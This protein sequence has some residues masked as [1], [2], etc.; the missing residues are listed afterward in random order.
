M[1][2]VGA[3]GF[4]C[5]VPAVNS[6]AA[7]H[8]ANNG[9]TAI[10]TTTVHPG[11]GARSI[12]V[13]CSGAAASS[14]GMFA[15]AFGV[16]AGA[17]RVISFYVYIETSLPAANAELFRLVKSTAGRDVSIGFEQSSSKICIY[18]Q[19]NFAGRVLGP[20]IAHSSWVRVDLYVNGTALTADWRVNGVAQ[21]QLAIG[22]TAGTYTE[23]LFG[24]PSAGDVAF[25]AY[26]AYYDDVVLSAT[27]GDYPLTDSYIVPYV[28]SAD[29]A[30]NTGG[31]SNFTN[32]AGTAITDATTTAW[33]NL[34]EIPPTTT[35]R[36]EQR[37]DTSG[38]RYVE[39]RF[40][41]T[42]AA[43][44]PLS[45]DFT[46]VWRAATAA[47]AAG[48]IKMRDG[49]GATDDAIVNTT[50]ALN[51]DVYFAKHYAA[52]PAALGAWTQA[53]LQDLRARVGFGT[54][55]TPD[56]WF[57]GIVAE[58]RFSAVDV[59]TASITATG[60]GIATPSSAKRAATS[61][62][63][64]GGGVLT[65]TTTTTR[66]RTQA[67][68]G[69]GVA[70]VVA[71]TVRAASVAV[72]GG[73]VATA[74]VQK[75]GSQT[76][77]ATGGG[78]ATAS[79]AKRGQVSLAATG[80]GVLA[81][82][83]STTRTRTDAATGGGVATVVAP[84]TRPATVGVSGGGSGVVGGT[85]IHPATVVTTGAGALSPSSSSIRA[86]S[87]GIT[88]GGVAT[89]DGE[90]V[91]SSVRDASVVVT[92]AGVTTIAA[93]TTRGASV[94]TTG[95]GV[96]VVDDV[97]I[98]AASI[99]ATG[100]GAAAVSGVKRAAAAIASSGSGIAIAN[101]TSVRTASHAATGAG[102]I[103]IDAETWRLAS[104]IATGGGA[105]VVFGGLYV[106]PV[107]GAVDVSDSPRD[108]LVSLDQAARHDIVASAQ[109]LELV[110]VGA[111]SMEV[112]DG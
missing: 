57:G 85:P 99:Q 103:P 58:A 51:T 38:A 40:N 10:S 19:T 98:R 48:Q 96:A 62:A 14:R 79:T 84:T 1:A 108:A 32:A 74:S 71:P 102:T 110:T 41:S 112:G 60:G 11:G 80:A 88:G 45:V 105:A 91:G 27:S 50:I 21:T 36:V 77:V 67:I 7:H 25:T 35:D 49:L 22:G 33:Q 46:T 70:T 86:A 106:P 53:A 16:A 73:G 61:H 76:L 42:A 90:A 13:T 97:F 43:A 52:R 6:V 81:P 37:L 68:A 24:H 29:G 104:V 66:T 111:G 63:A 18:S 87:V 2:T 59:R 44:A 31:G 101:A 109:G 28:P 56:I 23:L 83:S 12:K 20:A 95:G 15:T 107:P 92:G 65:Q 94:G 47:S 89:I 8:W 17:V 5:G 75:V 26:A 78:A 39:V 3:C 55:V 64:T 30:H 69:G 93:T 4:E 72:T 54:D 82:S 34:D 100:A 9:T